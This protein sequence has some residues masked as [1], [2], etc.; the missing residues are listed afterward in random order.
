MFK[1]HEITA[2][3]NDSKVFALSA[4]VNK[5]LE[6]Y[7]SSNKRSG[8]IIHR[9]I[10]NTY[11]DSLDNM[12]VNVKRISSANDYNFCLVIDVLNGFLAHNIKNIFIY[13]FTDDKVLFE[14]NLLKWCKELSQYHDFEITYVI[15]DKEIS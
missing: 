7:E 13:T 14:E 4:N 2:G 11:I 6:E 15:L 1:L 10:S 9:D 12:V 3:N 8:V 5:M